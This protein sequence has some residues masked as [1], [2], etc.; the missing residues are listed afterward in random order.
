MARSK[1]LA[2]HA[3]LDARDARGRWLGACAILRRE[4]I[5]GFIAR[6]KAERAEHQHAQCTV[7]A[8]PDLAELEVAAEF[9]IRDDDRMQA[10]LQIT[11][12][13]GA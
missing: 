9:V 1:V 7:R 11:L 13:G 8:A 4:P 6:K 10:A 5:A 12:D 3:R 2:R